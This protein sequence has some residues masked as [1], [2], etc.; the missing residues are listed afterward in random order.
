M[1]FIT[2]E[3]TAGTFEATV[4][5]RDYRRLG[6]AAAASRALL[7]TGRSL[8]E[9]LVLLSVLAWLVGR[10]SLAGLLAVSAFALH[11]LQAMVLPLLA[12]GALVWKDRRWLHALWLILPFLW[13]DSGEHALTQR[14]FARYDAEWRDW[15]TQV[16]KNGSFEFRVG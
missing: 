12:Y 5:P 7:V 14:L 13:M 10:Y 3:D 1:Q 9:P 6:R 4:F 11:P 16:N 15:I 2:L 8:A